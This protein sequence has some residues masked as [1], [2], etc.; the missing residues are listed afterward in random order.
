MDEFTLHFT[1]ADFIWSRNER[2]LREIPNVFTELRMRLSASNS[3]ID[4]RFTISGVRITNTNL[5]DTNRRCE[6]ILYEYAIR[7]YAIR[8]CDTNLYDTDIICA[9]KE[10]IYVTQKIDFIYAVNKRI[11]V[12]FH[13]YRN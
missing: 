8:I 12:T 4:G 7:I 11:L 9:E 3:N 13:R 2:N 6:F 5:Y 1:N 10:R